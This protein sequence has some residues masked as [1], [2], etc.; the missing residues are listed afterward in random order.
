MKL[1]SNEIAGFI[2]RPPEHVR[3]V[4]IYGPDGGQ[5]REV[6]DKIAKTIVE[7]LSDPFRVADLVPENLKEEPSRIADEAA[8]ISLTGGRRLVRLRGAT[9]TVAAA[10]EL[11]LGT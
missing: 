7:D 5:V 11:A 6:S 8:A 4:L 2:R 9:D 1:N 10:A 3:A